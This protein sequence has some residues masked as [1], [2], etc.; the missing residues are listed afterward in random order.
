MAT[1]QK[2]FKQ[3]RTIFN[4]RNGI[5]RMS[6][7]INHGLNRHT[8]YAMLRDGIIE[9]LSRGLYRL[10]DL[11]PMSDPD[12]ITVCRKVPSGVICLISALFFHEITSHIPREIHIA[13]LRHTE[14]PRVDYPP[15]RS[16]M[17]SEKAFNAGI[18]THHIDGVGIRIYSPAKT[19]ADCFKYR[20]NIGFDVAM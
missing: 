14:P 7:A 6:E 5:L 16:F 12:L 4:N 9:R 2:R 8:L 10:T 19:V 20:N 18:V 3:A 13:V 1:I 17:F 11:P 15:I